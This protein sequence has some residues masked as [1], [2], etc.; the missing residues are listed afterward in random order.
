MS[1]DFGRNTN[2]SIHMNLSRTIGSISPYFTSLKVGTVIGRNSSVGRNSS[3][4]LPPRG[5]VSFKLFDR[6]TSDF[7]NMSALGNLEAK[8]KSE[9]PEGNSIFKT[10]GTRIISKLKTLVAKIISF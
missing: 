2:N 4:G 6:G 1:I 8:I 3:D 10:M 7:A 5:I 9:N